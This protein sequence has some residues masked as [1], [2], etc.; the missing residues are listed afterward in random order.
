MI[1]RLKIKVKGHRLNTSNITQRSSVIIAQRLKS[2]EVYTSRRGLNPHRR[3]SLFHSMAVAYITLPLILLV[4]GRT[5][6]GL[7][8]ER[9]TKSWGRKRGYYDRKIELR[10]R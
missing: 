5:T 6:I 8:Y 2:I 7:N 1:E 10:R 9:K 4:K 3:V